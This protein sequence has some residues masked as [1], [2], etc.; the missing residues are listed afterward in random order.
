MMKYDDA[1]VVLKRLAREVTQIISSGHAINRSY[2]TISSKWLDKLDDI[3][4]FL[5]FEKVL[6]LKQRC[7][8]LNASIKKED[9][10]CR[11]LEWM[12]EMNQ[13][14]SPDRPIVKEATELLK[15]IEGLLIKCRIWFC[16]NAI[17]LVFW[18]VGAVGLIWV[19][20]RIFDQLVA[21]G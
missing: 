9:S 10:T 11:L 1:H 14:D 20:K 18:A 4:N 5:A 19:M 16:I 12:A 13:P 21:K 7:E 17:M 8:E 3:S 6:Q 2:P 15:M